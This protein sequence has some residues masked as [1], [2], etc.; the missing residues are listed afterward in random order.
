MMVELGGGGRGR[1][2]E[3]PARDGKKRNSQGEEAS[4]PIT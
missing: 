4:A 3:L 1:E 2:L